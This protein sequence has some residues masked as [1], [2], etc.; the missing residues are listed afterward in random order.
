M[1]TPFV[2]L[3]PPKKHITGH[4]SPL[5]SV[6]V[7]WPEYLPW[8]SWPIFKRVSP[9]YV[10]IWGWR[11]LQKI[12]QANHKDL[13]DSFVLCQKNNF[14]H[15]YSTPRLPFSPFFPLKKHSIFVPP[16]FFVHVDLEA[17]RMWGA[18][19]WAPEPKHQYSYHHQLESKCLLH[20]FDLTQ[21]SW[22]VRQSTGQ[23]P[24]TSP[25]P[26]VAFHNWEWSYVVWVVDHFCLQVFFDL[27]FFKGWRSCFK[28][29]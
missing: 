29:Y 26:V 15:I 11:L 21:K 7:P 1:K 22:S 8:F 2:T 10:S 4:F 14:P 5:G 23:V 28:N 25:T 12:I 18:S 9:R 27:S 13:A 16:I 3:Q 20:A 6:K 19:S 24:V 17:L